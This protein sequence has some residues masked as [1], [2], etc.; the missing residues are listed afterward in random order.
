VPLHYVRR[1][2][3]P[4]HAHALVLALARG[5]RRVLDVGAASG[6]LSEALMAQGSEVVAVEPDVRAAAAAAARGVQVRVGTVPAAVA[7]HEQ[8]DCVL[9]ADVVEHVVDGEQFLR[10][11]CGTWRRAARRCCRCRISPTSACGGRCCGDA[12]YTDTG[13]STARTCAST[14]RRCWRYSGRLG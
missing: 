14:R 12:T 7:A 3:D 9:A 4:D 8:F 13:C 1:Y 6:Y 11:L 2:D 10:D 5:A